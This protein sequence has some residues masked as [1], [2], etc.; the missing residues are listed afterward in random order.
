MEQTLFVLKINHSA[1][2]L[3]ID[4]LISVQVFIM[5]VFSYIIF[6]WLFTLNFNQIVSELSLIVNI[7][8]KQ[9][10]RDIVKKKFNQ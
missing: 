1:H 2:L 6:A 4:T 3:P 8:A 5:S 10:Q 7:L 9:L